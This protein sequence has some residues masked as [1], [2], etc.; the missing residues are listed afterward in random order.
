M[1]PISATIDLGA[2]THNYAL[3]K[4][5]ASGAKT[6]AVVKA[7][8]YGH[9]IGRAARA[10]SAADGFAV[11]ELD[12]AVR[13]RQTG[14]AQPIVLLEGFFEP[15]EL[16]VLAEH[17]IA[18]AI[19]SFEQIRMLETAPAGARVDVLLKLNTGMNRLGFEPGDFRSALDRLK[20]SRS[21]GAIT[22]MTHFANADDAR[23]VAWQMEIFERA[24][25][26]ETLP[27]SLAN[28]AAVLR[29][30]ETHAEIVRPA[31]CSTVARLSPRASAP[32]SACGRS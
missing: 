13:L 27:R 21:V 2:L 23:G 12:T 20:G 28:S 18:A 30:P 3:A 22:L 26:G 6:L 14:Y 8:A 32:R 5:R 19:H 29:Y 11:V 17:R 15:S 4:S 16:P 7:S 1:R 31:S 10:L 24:A 25:A 9:G